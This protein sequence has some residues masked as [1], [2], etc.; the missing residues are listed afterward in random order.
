MYNPVFKVNAFYSEDLS[1]YFVFPSKIKFF[2]HHSVLDPVTTMSP[3]SKSPRR[4]MFSFYSG[5]PES[6]S[7]NR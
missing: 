5:D 7:C 3:V 4:A 6:N 1:W 2:D